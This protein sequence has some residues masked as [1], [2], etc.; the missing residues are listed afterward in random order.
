MASPYDRAPRIGRRDARR[1]FHSTAFHVLE[2]RSRYD[3]GARRLCR[4]GTLHNTE[5]IRKRRDG[6]CTPEHEPACLTCG[7]DT[8]GALDQGLVNKTDSHAV[9]Y[10][11]LGKIAEDGKQVATG[12]C[13]G[14]RG[15]LIDRGAEQSFRLP[16]TQICPE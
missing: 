7:N 14:H 11:E 2:L 4:S 6:T 16:F 5:S 9:D 13:A 1:P 10:Q 12:E 3:V 8:A 15:G